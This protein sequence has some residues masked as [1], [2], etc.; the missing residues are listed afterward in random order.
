MAL[1]EDLLIRTG[2]PRS[3][4][5]R[6]GKVALTGSCLGATTWD[7]LVSDGDRL[8]AALQV[9]SAP[10][11]GFTDDFNARTEDA[12]SRALDVWNAFGAGALE[13]HPWLGYILMLEGCGYP[14]L[15]PGSAQEI[16][17]NTQGKDLA[18]LDR[19]RIFCK[20]LV[21]ERLYDAAC[22]VTSSSDP[23]QP[24]HQ[25]DPELSFSNM[26]AAISGRAAYLKALAR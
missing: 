12:L 22:F 10:A 11:A 25:P 13:H 26:V 18:N 21:R 8:L 9:R 7:L 4:I 3:G 1:V 19:Y 6:S 14:N 20:R 5:Q 15:P 24:V 2:F 23:N 16:A 17:V